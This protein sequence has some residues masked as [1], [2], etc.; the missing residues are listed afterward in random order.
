[1]L[2][3]DLMSI[4]NTPIEVKEATVKVP[5]FELKF[6]KNDALMFESTQR[7]I[8]EILIDQFIRRRAMWW[9]MRSEGYEFVK[10]S[11]F[12][13][14]GELTTASRAFDVSQRVLFY[15]TAQWA[16]EAV[17][18]AKALQDELTGVDISKGAD[19]GYDSAGQD[20]YDACV[21]ALKNLRVRTYPLVDVLIQALRDDSPI[22]KDA[23]E[24]WLEGANMLRASEALRLKADWSVT[25]ST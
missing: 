9:D 17:S 16:T 6:S 19:P 22:R 11:L 18:T 7:R 3:N 2:F 23:E 25:Y 24:K 8:E 5:F 20:R 10:K 4:L 1:M 15:T 21:E 12:E 13:L 14:G